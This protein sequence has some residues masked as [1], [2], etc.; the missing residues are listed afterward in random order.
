M[1]RLQYAGAHSAVMN[2]V[3]WE[4]AKEAELGSILQMVKGGMVCKSES[5][6]LPKME[7][8]FPGSSS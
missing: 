1:P 2:Q 8:C 4:I 7:M 3:P 5:W 6:N